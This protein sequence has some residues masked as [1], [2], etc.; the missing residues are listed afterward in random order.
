MDAP[1]RRD[2]PE[3]QPFPSRETCS[4]IRRHHTPAGL[5]EQGSRG[6]RHGRSGGAA[7]SGADAADPRAPRRRAI[8]ARGT[9][10]AG[11]T[12]PLYALEDAANRR[13]NGGRQWPDS[14]RRTSIPTRTSLP[15]PTSTTTPPLRSARLRPSGSGTG[16]P[17][18]VRAA[19]RVLDRDLDDVYDRRRRDAKASVLQV[20]TLASRTAD[21]PDLPVA[22]AESMSGCG[23]MADDG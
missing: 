4:R 14:H 6:A 8:P 22:I 3:L 23:K 7:R 13:L 15:G 2:R 18:D 20:P 16:V 9:L 19:V 12:R 11:L 17:S 5:S 1:P 21:R 10:L